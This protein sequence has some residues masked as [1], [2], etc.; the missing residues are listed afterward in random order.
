MNNY[1]GYDDE[2]W[3]E[4][5]WESH[6]DEVER[7]S[8]QLRKFI[9]SSHKGNTPRWVTLLDESLD[10]DDAFEAFVEEELLLDEAYFPED[11]DWDDEEDLDYD[12]DDYLFGR[13]EE[14]DDDYDEYDEGEDWKSLSEEYAQ[15]SHG[16]LHN[17]DTFIMAKEY[18]VHI[19]KW[20]EKVP[21]KIQSRE[22]QEFVGEVLTIG[23]K[24]A[25]G[26]SFGFDA[27][28]LGANIAYSKKALR[29]AN[30]SLEMLQALKTQPLFRQGEYA[31][32]H[33]TLFE[34]RNDIGVYVQELR[35]QFYMGL[36]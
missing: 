33:A 8:E 9:S 29:V 10:E 26:Y 34:L 2:L 15:S 36:E 5:K 1:D 27:E 20:A 22:F 7:K 30:T 17:L 14:E 12:E 6:L 4:F 32:M 28:Y 3:D 18:A 31:Q 25:G 23:A 11:E 35:D 13:S 24:L 21:P 19:L 16:S